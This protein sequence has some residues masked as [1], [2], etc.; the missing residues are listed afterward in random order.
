MKAPVHS[1]EA[2]WEHREEVVYPDLFG[3]FS[4]GT[5]ALTPEH[6]SGPF[7]CTEIDPRWLH[8]GVLEYGPT[9]NRDSWIYVTS[10][11][12]NPWEKEPDR[13]SESETSGF[14]T[15]LVLEVPTQ[16]EWA[17]VALCHMLAYDIL[18]AHGHFGDYEP[19]R[20]GARV[21]LGASIDG[22]AECLLRVVVVGS[23]TH[24]NPE[25]N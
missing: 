11:L 18:L 17:V 25:S 22:S 16:G 19:L 4:R 3:P 10:G 7:G 12:S 5:F 21:P 13:Y 23:A 15:E 9:P 24:Y 8:Y 14:G 2:V 1:L 20:V 6:F